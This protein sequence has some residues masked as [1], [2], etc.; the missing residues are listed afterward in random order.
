MREIEPGGADLG[1]DFEHAAEGGDG[2]LGFADFG[3]REAELEMNGGGVRVFAGSFFEKRDGFAGAAFL[4]EAQSL[5]GRR[6]GRLQHEPCQQREGPAHASI[7]SAG[8]R[9]APLH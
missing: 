1:V 5:G 6:G 7:V 9:R 2:A 4:D 3:E 8:L